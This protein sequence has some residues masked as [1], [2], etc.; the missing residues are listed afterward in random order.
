MSKYNEDKEEQEIDLN[1]YV[2]ARNEG[3]TPQE[4]FEQATNDEEEN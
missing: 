3:A 1:I 4:A 2:E